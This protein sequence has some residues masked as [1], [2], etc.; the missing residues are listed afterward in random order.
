MVYDGTYRDPWTG[1]SNG[2]IEFDNL[3][4]I[5]SDGTNTW[6]IQ[7]S[8]DLGYYPYGSA[9]PASGQG[10]VASYA[11]GV[12]ERHTGIVTGWDVLTTL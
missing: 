8:S 11:G 10:S 2:F 6:E 1:L 7:S 5:A 9:D 12:G 4:V 3:K